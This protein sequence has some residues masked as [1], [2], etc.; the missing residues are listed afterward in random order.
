MTFGDMLDVFFPVYTALLIG[1]VMARIGL[2]TSAGLT[3][4]ANFVFWVAIPALVFR[5]LHS[6]QLPGNG[7]SA[8]LTTYFA[9]A[10]GIF[11]VAYATA[12]WLGLSRVDKTIFAMGSNYSNTILVGLPII[13]H[14]V[15]P[16]GV[17]TLF[18]IVTLHAAILFSLAVLSLELFNA[19]ADHRLGIRLMRG[20]VE[21]PVA[22]A[23]LSGLAFNL[24]GIRVPDFVDHSFQM[25]GS[26]SVPLGL[27]LVGTGLGSADRAMVFHRTV[28]TSSL[29]KVVVLP[30]LVA[31]FCLRF[32]DFPREWVLAAVL[33]AGLP[34]GTTL[35]VFAERLEATSG[36]ASSI[37]FVSTSLSMLTLPALVLLF[38][39]MPA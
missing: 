27:F 36:F 3:G 12:R 21:N 5:E 38:A 30:L 22:I 35:V 14:V 25:I 33:T 23:A 15:G 29:L 19:G 28:M 2:A 18:W 31:A 37:F 13:S 8:L 6:S 10:V 26:A 32:F 34:A 7:A 9:T 11:L 4:A 20:L 16:L 24:A 39:V 1:F 17:T